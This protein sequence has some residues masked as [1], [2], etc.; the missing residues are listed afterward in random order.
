MIKDLNEASALEL[1]RYGQLDKSKAENV[2]KFRKHHGGFK[3][4]QEVKKVPGVKED[5]VNR[6]KDGF[7]LKQ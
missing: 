2:I 5:I 4:W 6:L 7:E 1:E 3:D